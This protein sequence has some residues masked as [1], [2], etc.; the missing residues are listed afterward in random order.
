[1][2]KVFKPVVVTANDL[3]EGDS[4]FL[5]AIGW[6]RDIRMA[7]VAMAAEEAGVL[8]TCGIEGE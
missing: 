7:R 5:G 3:I 1:M 2:A 6:V 8:E 4:V